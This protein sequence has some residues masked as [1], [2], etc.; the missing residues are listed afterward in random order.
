MFCQFS[1]STECLI[2]NTSEFL[3]GCAKVSHCG[4]T[5]SIL[6][7]PDGEQHSLAGK[8]NWLTGPPLFYFCFLILFVYL[9]I[10]LWLRW[11]FLAA[12]GLSLVAVSG[13]YS[14]LL[15]RKEK[16]L[17]L[18]KVSFENLFSSLHVLY[19][20]NSTYR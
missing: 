2:Q 9:Y 17:P 6:V 20:L 13:G 16:C 19:F 18:C 1:Q 11:V 4:G 15:Q 3:S 5:E 14:F 12:H 8:G 10:S 7:E